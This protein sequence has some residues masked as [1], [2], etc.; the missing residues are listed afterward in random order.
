MKNIPVNLIIKKLTLLLFLLA[1]IAFRPCSGQEKDTVK[2]YRELKNTIRLNL[3]NPLIFGDK[4]NVLGYERVINDYQTFSIGIGRFSFPKFSIIDKDSLRLDRDYKDRGFNFSFDYRFYLQKENLHKAPRGVY[5]G[6]FYAYN[7]FSRENHWALSTANF[8]GDLDTKMTM[9]MHAIGFQLGYQF[10][11]WNRV[12]LDMILVGPALWFF[13]LKTDVSTSLEPDD[14]AILFER[15][16][17]ALHD[18]FPNS[19]MVID[20]GSFK[21][22][23]STTT[24]SFGYR[25]M[26]N[27]GFRF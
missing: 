9:N 17:D 1:G 16:N 10:I 5:I 21:K 12:T 8:T 24:S 6:P 26:F 13:S 11:F 14:E 23:G 18:K 27:I 4:F 22:K 15:L 19:T 7:Y 25:Y 20:G 2:V 3:T